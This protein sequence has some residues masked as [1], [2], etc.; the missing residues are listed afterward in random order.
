MVLL[1]LSVK[2]FDTRGILSTPACAVNLWLKTNGTATKITKGTIN[3]Q[4]K[5]YMIWWNIYRDNN[6][7]SF[8]KTSTESK[9]SLKTLSF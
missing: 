5:K 7:F 4:Y 9:V 8:T 1:S 6:L 2:A 3:N